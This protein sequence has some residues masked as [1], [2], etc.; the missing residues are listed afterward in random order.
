MKFPALEPAAKVRSKMVPTVK[1]LSQG[2]SVPVLK[3]REEE[4]VGVPG[5]RDGVVY[6][7]S[8]VVA[9]K[10]RRKDVVTLGRLEYDDEGYFV[11]ARALIQLTKET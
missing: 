2:I 3:L 1:V 9:S 4:V 7:V 5:P 10:V 11:G 6:V 8:G